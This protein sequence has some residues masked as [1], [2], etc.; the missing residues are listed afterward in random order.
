MVGYHVPSLE[1]NSMD[2]AYVLNTNPNGMEGSV[3]S[4]SLKHQELG[5]WVLDDM[6]ELLGQVDDERFDEWLKVLP[7]N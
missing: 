5:N 3:A 6:M 1:P 2:G 4:S 7:R